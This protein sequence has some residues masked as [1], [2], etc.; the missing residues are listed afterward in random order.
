MKIFEGK[1][2]LVIGG[3]PREVID[4]VRHYLNQGRDQ[5]HGA[6]TAAALVAF[7]AKVT[8]IT[9]KSPSLP[10][11]QGL[12]IIER[13]HG[14]TI[15]STQDLIAAC[16]QQAAEDYDAV[17]QLANIPAFVPAQR[18]DHKLKVKNQV[19][20]VVSLDVIGNIGVVAQLQSLFP[21][22]TVVGYDN[23]QQ[24]VCVGDG[25]LS[26]SVRAVADQHQCEESYRRNES[27]SSAA[28]N[29]LKGRKVIITSGPTVE[30]L[31]D[32]G[33]V[34]TNF[35]SGRQGHAVAEALACM[36]AEVVLVSGQTNLA[37]PAC[38]SIRTIDVGSAQEMHDAVIS[39]LPADIFVGV[40]AVA[41]FG[42]PHP[43][44]LSLKEGEAHT[45]Q[46]RQ[47]PDILQAVGTHPSQRP[48]VVVGFAAETHDLLLYARDKLKRKGADFICANQVGDLMANRSSSTN[49]ITFVTLSG[50][51]EWQ[52]I[53]KIQVGEAIGRKIAQLLDEKSGRHE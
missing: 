38:E 31:T 50:H 28:G 5:G 51:E 52:E 47:N 16:V 33:D 12:E 17:V 48:S 11:V 10:I 2:L 29:E 34:I 41:D 3:S 36:G 22:S 8:F 19:E 6:R 40:A 7:G 39:E 30:P 37:V 24:W 4:G 9:A 13:V 53:P 46:L 15:I 44:T 27:R 21:R 32:A 42:L 23:R 35:S 25:E 1:H 14:H 26:Q 45:L 18:S 43:V 20:E 49:S